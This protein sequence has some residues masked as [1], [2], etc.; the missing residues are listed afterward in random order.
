MPVEAATVDSGLADRRAR[1][2]HGL[3]DPSRSSI[4][5]A[6][7]AGPLNVNRIARRT[8]L[9]QPNTSNHLACLQ[10]CGLVESERR[11][12]FVFY[13]LAD[14]VSRLLDAADRIVTDSARA[15]LSCPHC[16]TRV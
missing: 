8:G 15:I 2:F 1:L 14:D 12:R 5:Y 9:T 16:G 6:L 13:R 3:G 7:A 4:L 10:G 11:G